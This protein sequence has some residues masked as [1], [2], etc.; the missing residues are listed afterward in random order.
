[1]A[2]AIKVIER[3]PKAQGL[4]VNPGADAHGRPRSRTL[5]I[6]RR[7]PRKGFVMLPY[8][9]D[10]SVCFAKVDP[11]FWRN[12]LSGLASRPRTIPARWYYDRAGSELFEAII[13]LPEY[14]VARS[15]RALPWRSVRAGTVAGAMG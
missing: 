12:V 2:I 15:E 3:N 9:N 10:E 13:A 6:H 11:A 14:C 7:S 5:A 4:H 1:M 8:R